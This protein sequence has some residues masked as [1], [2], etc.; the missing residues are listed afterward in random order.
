M[1]AFGVVDDFLMARYRIGLED[2]LCDGCLLGRVS[3]A[4]VGVAEVRALLVRSESEEDGGGH[5]AYEGELEVAGV[6]YHFRCHAFVDS[7]GSC[8]LS[9]VSAFEPVAWQTRVA[10]PL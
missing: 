7:G 4:L 10:I 8:F 2:V 5:F 1:S 6:S 3:S 9:D